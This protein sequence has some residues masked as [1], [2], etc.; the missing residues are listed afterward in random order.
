VS[1]DRSRFLPRSNAYVG[2]M[3][4]S[5]AS[6]EGL[7]DFLWEARPRP[8]QTP[9]LSQIDITFKLAHSCRHVLPSDLY[10]L[11]LAAFDVDSANACPICLDPFCSTDQV[12]ILPCHHAFHRRCIDTWLLGKMS[13]ED[14][15]TNCCPVCKRSAEPADFPDEIPAWSY[16]RAGA[17]LVNV[18][19]DASPPPSRE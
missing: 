14:S 2:I 15:Y 18:E 10:R 8:W 5:P 11:P 12:R 4:H 7:K 9:L 6:T 19:D 16:L 1:N 13:H 17:S 3:R